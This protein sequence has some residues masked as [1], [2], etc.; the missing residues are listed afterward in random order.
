[1]AKKLSASEQTWAN[2][3]LADLFAAGGLVKF[4]VIDNGRNWFFSHAAE[5]AQSI[6]AEIKHRNFNFPAIDA[7]LARLSRL[8]IYPLH[9]A[10]KGKT[11]T[12]MQMANIIAAFCAE[13]EILWDDINTTRTTTE[14]DTYRRSI[15][16]RAC[17][18]FGCFLSQKMAAKD[19]KPRVAGTRTIDPVT[20]KAIPKNGYKASGPKS[21]SIGGLI[22]EPGEK[23]KFTSS[24]NLFVVVCTA[25]KPKKQ[26][27]FV[28]PV[29]YKADVNKVRFGDPSGYSTCKLVFNSYAAAAEAIDRVTAYGLKV[30][31]D[32][33][34]FEIMRHKIDANGY[35]N[36]KTEIGDAFIQASKLNEAVMEACAEE[37]EETKAT[38]ISDV[39][40]Y[41]EAFSRLS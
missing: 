40:V 5:A 25:D 37:P 3:F 16:G 29:S 34:G 19:T 17:W 31:T 38:W 35:F 39:D 15:L 27:I 12:A 1:M 18:E 23:I 9:A 32:V 14:M 4:N 10:G 7:H 8:T 41:A 26:Y 21:G 24:D 6:C 30:P 28:D 13:H 11:L 2:T 20:G 33:T 22:G 36:I